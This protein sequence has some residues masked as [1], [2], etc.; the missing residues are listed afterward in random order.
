MP[1]YKTVATMGGIGGGKTTL[2]AELARKLGPQ[3]LYLTEPDDRKDHFNPYLQDYYVELDKRKKDPDYGGPRWSFTIQAHLL[4]NR[5]AQQQ[6][7]QWYVL[8]GM[9]DAVIDSCYWQDVAFAHL[10][11]EMGMMSQR[12]F[13]SY[14][15]IYKGM[16]AGVMPPM[17]CLRIMTTPKVQQQR[18]QERAEKREGRK[19]EEV[20][21]LD[22]LIK[23]DREITRVCKALKK[24][25]TEIIQVTWD[26]SRDSPE[27][28]EATVNQLAEQ[29]RSTVPENP[30]FDQA[31]LRL[32]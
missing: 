16:T 3:T 17:F 28:R 22:Y 32:V 26:A 5:Y 24:M 1:L 14:Q 7:A 27:Q 18:I 21:P 9:G 25:G 20:I 13:D 30:L 2:T 31:H 23:L 6:A 15:M 10:Q 29:I 4:G 12:E 8:A 11:L 19:C